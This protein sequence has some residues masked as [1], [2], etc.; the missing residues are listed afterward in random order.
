MVVLGGGGGAVFNERGTPVR[1]PCQP[2]SWSTFRARRTSQ[3]PK[4]SKV[5]QDYREMG[6]QT[7]MVR[8]RTAT[9]AR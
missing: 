5:T 3:H 7:P 4:Y 9:S 6:V 8:G 1:G 2:P